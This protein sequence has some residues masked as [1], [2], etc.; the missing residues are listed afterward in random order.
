LIIVG[1]YNRNIFPRLM[2]AACSMPLIHAQRERIVPLASGEVVE[3]GIG[4]GLNLP[5]YD[6]ARVTRLVGVEPSAPLLDRTR[7]VARRVPFAVECLPASAERLPLPSHSVDT[8]VVTFSLCSIADVAAALAETRRVLRP[9]G[10]LLFLEHGLAPEESVQRWQRR[11]DPLWGRVAG[12]C[13]LSRDIPALVTAAGFR[14]AA[15]DAAYL[16]G[17]PR[18]AGYLYRG[19]F[20][21]L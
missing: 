1:W 6:P 18:F 8:A 19:D 4:S 12:G 16:A 21:P 11:L 13:H 3:I 17:A 5:L 10:R 20:R 2:H 14:P 15:L 7:K 9:G